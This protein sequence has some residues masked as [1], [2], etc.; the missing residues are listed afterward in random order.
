M[1]KDRD[2]WDR[3]T[4][5]IERAAKHANNP[6]A[7]ARDMQTG[8]MLMQVFELRRIANKLADVTEALAQGRGG[9]VWYP[10][11]PPPDS[12]TGGVR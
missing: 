6:E 9:R 8:A 7:A 1:L 12:D 5:Y 10:K 4:G 3:A 2:L 11:P